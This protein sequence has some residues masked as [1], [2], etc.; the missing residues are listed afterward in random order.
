MLRLAE[1]IKQYTG[2]SG[3]GDTPE[4]KGQCVGLIEVWLDNLGLNDPHLYGN[5]KD[6]LGNA[7]SNKFDIILN[8]PN[9][10]SQFPLPGDIAVFDSSWGNGFGHTGITVTANGTAF[11]LFEQN[12]PEGSAPVVGSH[13]NYNGVIGWLHPKV[14]EPDPL[15]ACLAQHTALVDLCNQKDATIAELR[16]ANTDQQT[17]LD[18][19]KVKNDSLTVDRNALFD[20]NTGLKKNIVEVQARNASLADQVA[21]MEKADSTAV[22]AGLKAQE[23]LKN[24]QIELAAIASYLGVINDPK[25]VRDKITLLQQELQSAQQ[26]NQNQV[27]SFQKYLQMFIDLFIKKK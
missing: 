27:S 20:E 7:D 9:D 23:L 22:D 6:L 19:A 26:A 3:T 1:F 4:N 17:Q 8:N 24:A 18:A 15:Q 13:K 16:K 5:A 10:L 21:Q 14:V 25:T 12:N 11:D 2:V